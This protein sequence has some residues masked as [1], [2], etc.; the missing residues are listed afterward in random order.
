MRS[1]EIDV[2]KKEVSRKFGCLFL[3]L[4]NLKFFGYVVLLFSPL[5]GGRAS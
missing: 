3:F 1:K 2:N 5:F 4:D